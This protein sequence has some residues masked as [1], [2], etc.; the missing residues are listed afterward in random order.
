M[1]MDKLKQMMREAGLHVEETNNQL[2][3]NSCNVTTWAVFRVWINKSDNL[4]VKTKG[5]QKSFKEWES[6]D[7]LKQIL[8]DFEII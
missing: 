3:G 5:V 1:E 6:I 2:R 4:T 8:A 7:Q